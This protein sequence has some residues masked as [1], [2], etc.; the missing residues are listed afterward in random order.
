MDGITIYNFPAQPPNW[1][2]VGI[3]FV[4]FAAVWTTIVASGMVFCLWNR[5]IPALKIRSLPLAFAGITLLH[6][7]WCMAQIVYPIGGTMPMAIA[8]T[9]Q[10]FIMGMSCSPRTPSTGAYLLLVLTFCYTNPS[11]CI[12]TD[13]S[14]RYMVPTWHRSVPRRQSQVLA[15]CGDAKTIRVIRSTNQDQGW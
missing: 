2:R 7:Y 10:Y 8:Y 9:V 12:P 3:F 14:F 1:D 15:S 13:V 4:T 5:H 6:L 11:D